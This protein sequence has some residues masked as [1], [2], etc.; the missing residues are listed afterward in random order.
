VGAFVK[1]KAAA[2]ELGKALFWDMQVGSDGVTAC[3]TCH[4]S[5]GAD[6]RSRNQL[7][8]RVRPNFLVNGPN[9]QLSAADFPFHRLAD[10][11][12][13]DSA[14][15]FDTQ[16]VTGS[17]GVI[18]T[19]FVA[20]TPGS[21]VDKVTFDPTDP[22]FNV[23]GVNV[24][25]AT[26]RNTPTNIN[27]IFNF[28]NFWDGRA[29]NEFN[30]VTPFGDRDQTQN[31][32]VAQVVNGNVSLVRIGADPT[33]RL[34]NASPAS[35]AVGPPGNDVEMSAAGRTLRD[36]GR[37]L[38][39]LKPLGEQQV[40]QT[41]SVLGPDANGMGLKT[42]YQ[43]LIRKAFHGRWWDSPAILTDP[44][45]GRQ[46][47]VMEYNFSLFWGLSIQLWEATLVSDQTPV[48]RFLAGDDAAIDDQAKEG[49]SVF[50]GKGRCNKC[51]AGPELTTASVN[52]INTLGVADNSNVQEPSGSFRRRSFDTG[53][54]NIGVTR[55][56]DDPGNGGF[57]PFGNPLSVTR[58]R[59]LADDG[60]QGS[61][62]VAS[63][64]NVELTAPYFHNGGSLTLRQVVDFYSRGGNFANPEQNPNIRD[65]GLSD[66]EKDALV[67]FL[68]ALTD[69]RV[70]IAAAPFDHPQ[71]FVPAGEQVNADQSIKTDANG[72][73][74]DC[75]LEVPATGAAGGAAFPTF[76]SFLFTGPPCGAAPTVTGSTATGGSGSSGSGSS[77]GGSSGSG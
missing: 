10:P 44:D 6:L 58:L 60:V 2:I 32:K 12:N 36:I 42:S 59:G 28:R 40:S 70:R 48:D 39:A 68:M 3:A 38:F 37:K 7:N 54:A 24:R 62:K 77:G 71:L 26:G 33:L 66:Q 74:V 63:L 16:N 27:A 55:T 65:L 14:V 17:Q 61:F 51:H 1:D 21:A 29:Q 41:D 19:H 31:A 13:R 30:G 56:G 4:F 34:T 73:A 23:N 50:G 15:L 49:L 45:N 8:P 72:V 69:E 18:P 35:Q 75:F 76:A 64:R 57:D 9:F 43:D 5:A 47:T 25:R 53:F 20:I 52:A 67:A 11:N 46:Y 22:T